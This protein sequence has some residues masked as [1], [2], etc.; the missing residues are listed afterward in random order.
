MHSGSKKEPSRVNYLSFHFK[1]LEKEEYNK[2]KK[3]K[4]IKR[5]DQKLGKLETENSKEGQ[6]TSLDT[7]L[8]KREFGSLYAMHSN[9]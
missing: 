6:Q 9:H 8:G 5:K 3:K 7:K 1:Q 2:P 4:M